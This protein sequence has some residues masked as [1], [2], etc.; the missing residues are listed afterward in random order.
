MFY[1]MLMLGEEQGKEGGRVKEILSRWD[2]IL[3]YH[4]LT[5]GIL[6]AGLFK[7]LFKRQ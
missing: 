2:F 7:P 1:S 6:V 4:F 5:Y 3:W